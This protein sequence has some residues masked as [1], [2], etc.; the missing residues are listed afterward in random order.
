MRNEI[1][2]MNIEGNKIIITFENDVS[3]AD[4]K[5]LMNEDSD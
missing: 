3:P 1:Q 4:I 2:S 5:E